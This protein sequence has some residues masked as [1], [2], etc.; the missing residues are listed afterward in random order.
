[1]AAR[2]EDLLESTVRLE[3]EKMKQ[4]KALLRIFTVGKAG[5]GKSSLIRDLVGPTA[6]R[7]PDVAAGWSACTK[8]LSVYDIPV[9][10]GVSV[11]VYDTRGMFD[12]EA[13]SHENET[14]NRLRDVCSN[15]VSG[16]LVVCIPMHERLDEAAPLETLA[17]LNREIGK[18]IW[19]YTVIALTKADQY[20]KAEWL[21]SKKW[22]E[23]S[24]P[25]LKREFEKTLASCKKILREKFTLT[26]EA[27]PGC[28]IGM[29]EEEYDEL[30]IPIVP[31]STLT[32]DL[33]KMTIVGQ[34]HWFDLLL[35]ECCKRERSLMLV[36]IHSKRIAILPDEIVRQIRQIAEVIA[37]EFIVLV[38]KLLKTV[39]DKTQLLVAWNLYRHYRY[40]HKV[41]D[42]PRFETTE[43]VKVQTENTQP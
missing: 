20:P 5:V 12:A 22:H 15:D 29:T 11:H 30:D 23:K 28:C 17:I 33:S 18:E 36:N 1:M 9:E 25:I 2:Q 14:A 16:V 39:G 37:P 32:K 13:G 35:V 27:R 43:S 42:A 24:A 4:N 26:K 21:E 10:D 19:R 34:E 31:T 38:K 41:V 6:K 3:L 8:K 40:S 7:K